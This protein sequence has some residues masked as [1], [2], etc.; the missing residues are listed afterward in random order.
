M[1][2]LTNLT[3]PLSIRVVAIDDHVLIREAVRHILGQA[4]DIDLVAQGVNGHAVYDLIKQHQPHVALVDL[5]MPLDDE[6]DVRFE[7]ISTIRKISQCYPETKIIILSQYW[8]PS[9]VSE[10]A[11]YLLKD[12]DLCLNLIDAI[13]VVHRGG[14]YRSRSGLLGRH[15][16]IIALTERQLDVLSLMATYPDES[17]LSLAKRLNI[18]EYTFRDYQSQI[19]QVLNVQKAQSAILKAMRLGILPLL[20]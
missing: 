5:N 1:H 14:G 2:Q 8:L 11:G 13:R 9:V 18:S 10:V 20:A 4:S 17:C 3:V 15:Q 16:P 6:V 7:P 12:D 19:Y